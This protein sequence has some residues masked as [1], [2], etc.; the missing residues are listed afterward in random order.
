MEGAYGISLG[1][2]DD[3]IRGKFFLDKK[4]LRKNSKNQLNIATLLVP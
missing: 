1:Q 4:R 3:L 2:K